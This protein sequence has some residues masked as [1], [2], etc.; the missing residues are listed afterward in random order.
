MGS[1]DVLAAAVRAERQ[2]VGTTVDLVPWVTPGQSGG[3]GGPQTG[4]PGG[5]MYNALIQLFANGATGFNACVHHATMLALI[6]G[7]VRL[8]NCRPAF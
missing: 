8:D 1:L 4:D 3:T 5:V 6:V 2:W 7:A